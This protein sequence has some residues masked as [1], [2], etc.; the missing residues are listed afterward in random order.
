MSQ[1]SSVGDDSDSLL[2]T[3][4][5]PEN[6]E[7]PTLPPLSYRLATITGRENLDAA[8]D[9]DDQGPFRHLEIVGLSEC[10]NGR[11][12]SR[13]LNCGEQVIVG[14]IMRLQR[15]IDDSYEGGVEPAVACVLLRG[16][17]ETCRVAFVPRVFINSKIV[18]DNIDRHI[19]VTEMFRAS[20]NS[21]KR[22]KDFLNCGVAGIVFLDEIPKIE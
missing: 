12:C 2:R 3:V 22:R 11:C 20:P 6:D 15:C 13:H 7:D 1:E 17:S 10:G 5:E 9:D 14:D 16:G 4:T 8:G 21:A 18:R 19:Q